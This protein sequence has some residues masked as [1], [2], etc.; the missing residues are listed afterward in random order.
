MKPGKPVVI[1]A[2]YPL[3]FFAQRIAGD[4]ATVRIP[5]FN[6]DPAFWKPDGEQT[7]ALQQA[8]LLLLNGAGY[9]SWRDWVTL[10]QE[11]LQDTSRGFSD[12][13]IAMNDAPVHQ[14]G[15]GGEHSH[16]ELAF[17]TWLDPL[18]A[19]EQAAAAKRGLDRLLPQH[20]REFQGRLQE[21]T[22]QLQELDRELAEALEVLGDQPVIFS[23]PVYQYLAGRYGLDGVSVHWEPDR[24]PGTGDWIELQ[25]HLQRHPARFMLWEDAPLE[26][27]AERLRELGLEP[28]VFHTLALPPAEGDYFDGMKANI[29]RLQLRGKSPTTLPSSSNSG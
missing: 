12:R 21:L 16:G 2:N 3:Y 25:R 8:D 10:S 17:T 26:A 24:E 1:A 23:H 15:P 18:L 11:S 14:H 7:R 5:E 27:V 20:E 19:A 13:L 6:G 9:E 28:L 22:D 29:E 4:S